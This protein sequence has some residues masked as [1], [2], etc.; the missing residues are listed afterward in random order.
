MFTLRH[1]PGSPETKAFFSAA[2]ELASIPGVQNFACLRQVS[3]KNKYQYGLSMEFADAQTYQQYNEH[4]LHTAFIQEWWMENVE[5]F[6]EMD[7]EG[8]CQ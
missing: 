3:P 5:E 6:S 7:F 8:L 4:P 1:A 2:Q